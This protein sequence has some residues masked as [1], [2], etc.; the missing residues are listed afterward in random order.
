MIRMRL[1][2][3]PPRGKR[4]DLLSAFRLLASRAA[5]RTG[6][7]YCG[8]DLDEESL[9]IVYLEVWNSWDELEEYIRSDSYLHL[10]QLMELSA[11]G[12]DLVFEGPDRTCGLDWVQAV[13]GSS[14][15]ELI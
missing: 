5:V 10:L 11:S 12:P 13:R 9:D 1:Q 2:I 15:R 7:T 3:T 4:R 8:L 6:C 14:N